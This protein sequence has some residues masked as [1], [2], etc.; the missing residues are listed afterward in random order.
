VGGDGGDG[1]GGYRLG[2]KGV[3]VNVRLFCE[4][5]VY[6]VMEWGDNGGGGGS[7]RL[8]KK[9][10]WVNVKLFCQRH[11]IYRQRCLS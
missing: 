9:C 7:L 3:C 6:S 11:L 2:K 5:S 1:G 4:Y 8:G 10:G